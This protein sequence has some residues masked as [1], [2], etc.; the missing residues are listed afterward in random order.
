M[1][2]AGFPNPAAWIRR[3]LSPT[4]ENRIS[5]ASLPNLS[6]NN[7][8]IE[9]ENCIAALA[10]KGLDVIVINTMHPGL[11]IPAFYTIIPGAHFRERSLGDQ[12][13]DVLPPS[14]QRAAAGRREAAIRELEK[15]LPR[16]PEYYI[17]FYLGQIL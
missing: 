2:P 5:I 8:R 15:S 14:R 10:E 1:R 12:R 7:I 9:V 13:R 11:Q 17:E 4:P 3:G 16:C 6:D